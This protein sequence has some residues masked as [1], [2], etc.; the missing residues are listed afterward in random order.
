MAEAF[1]VAASAVGIISLALQLGDGILKLK[2]FWGAVKDA[3]EEILYILDELDITHVLLTE[4]EDSL[5]SQ[6]I[7][8]A[9]ARSLRLCQKGVDILNNAVRELEGEMGRRKKWGGVKMVMK[10]ELLEKMEKRLERANSLMMMAHQSYIESLNKSRHHEQV[11]L[12]TQQFSEMVEIRNTLHSFN[13]AASIIETQRQASSSTKS[14]LIKSSENATSCSRS[15]KTL[16]KYQKILNAKLRLPF[17]SGVWELCAY[18]QSISGWTFTLRTYNLVDNEAPIM[19]MARFGD[20]AG[21]QQLFQKRQ[22][23]LLD[24]DIYGQTILHVAASFQNYP[25]CR[26]LID[27]GAD[28]DLEDGAGEP[29][30]ASSFGPFNKAKGYFAEIQ[31]MISRTDRDIIS[32]LPSA[33]LCADYLAPESFKWILQSTE[34]PIYERSHRERALLVLELS[35]CNL[36]NMKDL[37]WL[38]LDNMDME[39]CNQNLRQEEFVKLL[40]GIVH[41]LGFLIANHRAIRVRYGLMISDGDHLKDHLNFIHDLLVA[42]SKYHNFKDTYKGYRESFL[43]ELL[44]GTTTGLGVIK[45]A[46]IARLER[47]FKNSIETWLDQLISAEIDL[48]EYGQWEK[49]INDDDPIPISNLRGGLYHFW[50]R[51]Y[52][53]RFLSFTYGPKRSDWQFWF[54]FESRC[55]HEGCIMEFWDM[56][57][58][59]ERQMP[60]AW[61]F[62]A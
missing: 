21:M 5:G 62:D 14:L 27:H 15:T 2:S 42:G 28:A 55:I 37:A 23:S 30:W 39:T 8:P 36:L 4:I 52:V 51:N 31:Y 10:K 40:R 29:A 47:N 61:N 33:L 12:A 26:F 16:S 41:C 32:D 57:E 59:P 6:T 46:N 49:K 13:S 25:A 7:S 38:T 3:P 1:G 19:E 43:S 18:Q 58:N 45:C 20:V 9:A 56:V 22:A 54:I 53:V 34:N 44:K 35:R 17:F 48:I 11:R 50:A 24:V 60:G